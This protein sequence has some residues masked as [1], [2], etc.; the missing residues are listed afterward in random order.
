[1]LLY[2]KGHSD[3]TYFVHVQSI[4]VVMRENEGKVSVMVPEEQTV[5]EWRDISWELGQLLKVEVGL[6]IGS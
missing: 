5:S 2:R 4:K 3:L 6:R 1:M